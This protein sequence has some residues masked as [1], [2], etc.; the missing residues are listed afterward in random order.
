MSLSR[1]ALLLAATAP[2]A[3]R[4]QQ[5]ERFT[6]AGD[7]VAVHNVAGK[8]TIEAGNGNAVVVEVTRGGANANRLK[9]EQLN[10]P[11]GR[12]ALCVVYPNERII[13]RP[14]GAGNHSSWNTTTSAEGECRGGVKGIFGDRKVE[15]RSQGA[16]VEAWADI[17]IL[18]PAGRDVKVWNVVG[19]LEAS[20][21]SAT[22]TLDAASA[23][24][25]TR[26]TRGVLTVE[27]G[28]SDVSVSSH[29]GDLTLEVGSGNVRMEGVDAKTIRVEA[30][31]GSLGGANVTTDVF[32]LNT[33]SGNIEFGSV[34]AHRVRLEAGSGNTRL[35]FLTSV[36]SLSAETGSGNVTLTFPPSFGAEV[37]IETGSGGISSDFAVQAS[38]TKGGQLRGTIG[39]GRGRVM[40][41]AG[42]GRVEL[43]RSAGRDARL[44]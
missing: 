32:R 18:V 27:V 22:L 37:D 36:D 1:I 23:A 29:T 10:T 43:R 38:R 39:N 12:A 25:N 20:N 9:I 40:I 17:H 5:V 14:R 41:E 8:V 13:Y 4:P 30:G 26:G 35:A 3:A 44:R 31:S 11:D 2:V 42:S 28:S 24:V 33:G 7:R 19:D 16:G 6:L 15:V 21:V 34:T